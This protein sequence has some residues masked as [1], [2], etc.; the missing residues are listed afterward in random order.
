ML[1]VLLIHETAKTT[2]ITVLFTF[3]S[4]PF[5]DTVRARHCARYSHHCAWVFRAG[6]QDLKVSCQIG[7]E[8][9]FPKPYLYVLWQGL[10]SKI[11]ANSTDSTK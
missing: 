8:K 6:D 10:S 4:Y 1:F 7:D 3:V 2:Y 9:P 11:V 5:V